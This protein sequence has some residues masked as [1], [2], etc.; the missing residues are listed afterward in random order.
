MISVSNFF[1]NSTLS[2]VFPV[3]V[4]PNIITIGI[5]EEITD[6]RAIVPAHAR[7]SLMLL[8]LTFGSDSCVRFNA[9]L[10]LANVAFDLILLFVKLKLFYLRFALIFLAAN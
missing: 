5:R 6:R 7:T 9:S 10:E 3:P 8:F 1:A 4:A 2:L